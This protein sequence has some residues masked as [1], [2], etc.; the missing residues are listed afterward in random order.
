MR[1][2]LLNILFITV[3]VIGYSQNNSITEPTNGK[4]KI[5]LDCDD[6][7]S[8]FFRRNLTFV[9]FVRDAKLADIHVFVTEQRTASNGTEY[10]LNFIGI[11]HYS[12]IQYK[13]KTVSPQDETDIL[14]WD[15]L[16]KIIDIGLL[17]Y[18]SRTPELARIKIEHDIDNAPPLQEIN[19][20]WNYW[21]FRLELGAEFEAEESQKEY[22]LENSI[23]ADRITE[24]LKFR[25]EVSYEFEKEIYNDDDEIIE[26][27]KEEVEFESR[28]IYSLSPKW[29]AGIFG[30]IS[31]SSYYNLKVASG[32][33]P[34]I[35][36]NIFPW[37]KSDRKVF[38]IAYHLSMN[39][40]KYNELTIYGKLEEWRTSQSLE[41]S[42]ILRQ[43]WG[44][45]ENTLEAS[46]YFY[47]FLNNRLSLESRA[48]IQIVKGLSLFMELETE[49]I[50]DQL[51]L[52]A[53]E[54]TRDEMLLQQRKL[55]TK[56]EISAGLGIR[57]T[58]GSVY[59][60]IVNQRL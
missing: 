60:N 45:I 4:I 59:N 33:G 46:H 25:S 20:P 42:F 9:D 16:L 37:D 54:I 13:L 12:D 57:V 14:K 7:N 1:L 11:N 23:R 2:L 35:E 15:R 55:A 51:Y 43:P 28:L 56:F 6:C 48:S 30:E 29:S 38:T 17:P 53:G 19:D 58:I 21:V 34:A 18:L 3:S 39:Y 52:P 24:M 44:E 41:L 36:Y 32:I 49:F 26:S 5:Y 27:K 10:G 31:A 50:H 47:N 8:S 22:S 40:F